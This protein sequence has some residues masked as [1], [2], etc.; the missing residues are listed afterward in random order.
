MN[1]VGL[2]RGNNMTKW[3]TIKDF[4]DYQISDDGKVKSLKHGKEMILSSVNDGRGYLIVSLSKDGKNAIKR[5]HRLVAEAF[6][7]N[8]DNL[9]VV[10][11]LNDISNDN[12]IEN[13]A[14]GTDKD[15]IADSIKNNLHPSIKRRIKIIA[16]KD[17]DIRKYDSQA[18]AGRDLGIITSHIN[19]CVNR[20]RKSAG[21]YIFK[22]LK[23]RHTGKSK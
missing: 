10:R 3:R 21:G 14:W 18:N 2:S 16:I 20:K 5:I 15:N 9:P 19:E 11:H 12:R 6:I 13:L 1:L 8:P 7:P 23:P 4:P 17:D 22:K